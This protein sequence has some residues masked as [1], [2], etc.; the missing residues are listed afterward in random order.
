MLPLVR[1][2]NP[3]QILNPLMKRSLIALVV[4]VPSLALVACKDSTTTSSASPPPSPTPVEKTAVEASKTVEATAQKVSGAV[5]DAAKSAGNTV[6]DATAAAGAK[7]KEVLGK[8]QEFLTQGKLQEAQDSLK[9]LS[10][11]KLT[12]D[13]QKLVDDLKAKIQQAA[14]AAKTAG[15]EATKAV[16]GLLPK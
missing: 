5:Q 14:A 9:S 15:G 7:F 10:D 13:Q 6:S 3:I 2:T 1:N 16:Q 4:L 12:A 8:A 11:L